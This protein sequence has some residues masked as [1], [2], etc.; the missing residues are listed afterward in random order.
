MEELIKDIEKRADEIQKQIHILTGHPIYGHVIGTKN[1][2]ISSIIR[3][4]CDDLLM[5]Q[6]D[7]KLIKLMN[8]KEKYMD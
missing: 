8:Y 7:L 1:N 3:I 6:Q 5:I 2:Q 4:I